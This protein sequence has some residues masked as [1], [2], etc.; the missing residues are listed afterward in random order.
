MEQHQYLDIL[1]L[2]RAGPQAQPAEQEA[3]ESV[4]Q[5]ERHDF[6]SCVDG[7]ANTPDVI[8]S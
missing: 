3:A 8:T 1:S 5:T 2:G 7:L 6:Q 4:D